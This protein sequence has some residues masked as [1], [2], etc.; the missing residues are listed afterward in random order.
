[1][2]AE[3]GARRFVFVSSIKVL[4]EATGN[5]PF[6]EADVPCPQDH[7]AKSKL[8]AE[9]GLR[10]IERAT[11]MQV[12]ILRPPL[13][14][15]PGVGA[16]FLRL[17]RLVA[18]GVPLP[19]GWVSNRRSLLYVGNLV[20]ALEVCLL[21]PRA[22]GHVFHAT[23]GKPVSTGEL[24]I[25]MARALGVRCHL[26]PVPV[27]LL[28]LVGSLIG[29]A[30]RMGRLLD[31]LEVDDSALRTDLGWCPPFSMEQGLAATAAWFGTHK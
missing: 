22:A 26:L 10:E 14:Y 29:Q 1:M 17:M 5:R 7:Y 25:R 4:G 9:R 31:S 27:M 20:S 3:A 15:G 21:H 30:A 8:Q 11:G 24:C 13:V 12:V 16:N 6:T 2:A 23:D 19:F 28:R 18:R